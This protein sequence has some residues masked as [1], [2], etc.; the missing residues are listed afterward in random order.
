MYPKTLVLSG[1]GVLGIATLG[2]LTII[3]E[4]MNLS[5]VQ[6]VVGSSVGALI[7]LLFSIGMSIQEM[8]DLILTIDLQEL[9][10]LTTNHH[11][12]L[13]TAEFILS[14]YGLDD[15]LMFTAFIYDLM[16]SRNV[17][18]RLTFGG[19]LEKYGK[20]LVITGTNVD[21]QEV[22]YFSVDSHES[23]RVVDAIRI[24]ASIPWRFTAPVFRGDR[25]SDGGIMDNFPIEWAYR[26]ILEQNGNG[27]E[28]GNG[29]TVLAD[30]T[31]VGVNLISRAETRVEDF[32][33][34]SRNVVRCR[35][36]DKPVEP[37]DAGVT[38]I[39]VV[40]NTEPTDFFIDTETKTKL[41]QVGQKATKD[42]LAQREQTKIKQLV[43]FGRRGSL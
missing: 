13:S 7:G 31:I 17:D 11:L 33:T 19:L 37:K 21:C 26:E 16:L 27:K 38:V 39:N 36:L 35:L 25:W 6:T 42:Y 5:K 12:T 9:F 8:R 14:D 23:M 4:T 30:D 10:S 41:F 22:C 15:G 1:G 20:K 2:A 3:S 24:S 32:L 18:P 34:F 29:I 28:N 40:L 43:S